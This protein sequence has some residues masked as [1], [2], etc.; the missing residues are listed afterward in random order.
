MVDYLYQYGESAVG[1]AVGTWTMDSKIAFLNICIHAG[2]YDVALR[3]PL[4][5][6]NV[7]SNRVDMASN[8]EVTSFHNQQNS[9]SSR[10]IRKSMMILAQNP[11]PDDNDGLLNAGIMGSCCKGKLRKQRDNCR[12]LI[13][14]LLP[15]AYNDPKCHEATCL[16][17]QAANS[18][19]TL[20]VVELIRR[21]PD[22]VWKSDKKHGSIFH[23]AVENRYEGIF[24][25]LH[26]LGSIADM[27]VNEEI[28]NSEEERK[29]ILHLAAELSPLSKRNRLS[30]A[31]LQMHR[32]ALWFKEVK[33]MVY[34]SLMKMTNGQ[35]KTPEEVFVEKHEG[36]RKAGEKWIKDTAKSSM[37]VAT[38][39]A[40]VAFSAAFSV[41]GGF[42]QNSGKPIL[43]SHSF[44]LAFSLADGIALVSS[45][46]S[47]LFF[48]SI[49]TSRYAVNDFLIYLPLKL[50]IG[51]TSLFTSIG[52]MA[53]SFG[54][55][56][57][58]YNEFLEGT[59]VIY[60]LYFSFPF[61][62]IVYVC[63]NYFIF[64]DMIS[65]AFA[66]FS[67][68]QPRQRQLFY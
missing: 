37:I 42:D 15:L 6:Q 47:L 52:A 43:L 4:D 34:P 67:L 5:Q 1:V 8:N 57:I 46:L 27:I 18:G 63:L 65:S 66:F 9:E 60:F 31:A 64:R 58:L 48:L 61:L 55:T 44:F 12:E 36:M 25:L 21:N 22:I 32:D 3:I 28:I 10:N 38:L 11:M 30:G 14:K 35:D 24:N 41:P 26:E 62:P 39:I 54:A 56:F 59:T 2:F 33:K 29:N 40:T 45:A 49:L 50:M 17:F 13:K 16:L 51:S 23:L 7:G 20:M 68:F 19:N 53:I